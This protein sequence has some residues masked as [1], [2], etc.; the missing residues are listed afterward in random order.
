MPTASAGLQLG[1]YQLVSR[2]G[3]GGMGEVWKGRDTRIN[4]TVAIKISQQQFSE[5]FEREARS[6]AAL[7]HPNICALYDVGPDYLVMEYVDGSPL[8]HVQGTRKLLDTAV[9]IADGLA[10]AHAAGIVHRDLKPDNVLLT[11]DGRVKILDFGLAKHEPTAPQ[12]DSDLTRTAGATE[13][14]VVMGTVSYMS[15]EQVRGLPLDVR[16]DQFS[17]GTMLYELA[18]GKRP[19]QRESSVQTM[20]AI[21]EADPEP[22]PASVPAPIRWIVE[23]CLAKEP[24]GRYESTRD[25]YQDLRSVR[26]HLSEAV[27][28]APAP[29]LKSRRLFFATVGTVGLI[30]VG[31]LCFWLGTRT[32]SGPQALVS[33]PFTSSGGIVQ[34]PNFSPD[35]SQ[36]VFAWNGPRQTNFNLYVKLIGSNDTL[37]L[38]NDASDEG[39][40]AWSPDGKHIAFVRNLGNGKCAV[41]ITS[42]IGGAERK[43]TEIHATDVSP[44]GHSLLAWTP[45]SRYLAVPDGPRSDV[46]HQIYLISTD[47]A[48][49]RQLTRLPEQ[50]L[51][52]GI[53]GDLDPA[54]SAD[55]MRLAFVRVKA[56]YSSHALWMPLGPG[57]APSGAAKD[58]RSGALLHFSPLWVGNGQLLLSAGVPGALRLCRAAKPD[59][60]ATPLTNVLT[61]GA[62]ALNA[63]F[64][65]LVFSSERLIQNLV[66]IS[67]TGTG[68]SSRVPERLTATTGNDFLPHY[69][70]DGKSV[71]FDSRRGVETGIWT[72]R[73]GATTGTELTSSNDATIA[74]GD[75][76]PDGMSLLFCATTRPG[77]WQLFRLAADSG[78]VTQLV[79]DASHKFLPTSS[80]DGKWIYFTSS[81]SGQDELYRMPSSGGPATLVVPL[82]VLNARESP[83]GQWLYFADWPNGGVSR[84]PLRGGEIARVLDKIADPLAY[85]ITSRGL[86]YFAGERSRP[87]L[88]F[89]DLESHRSMVVFRPVIPADPVL[90]ISPDGRYICYPQI[91]HHSQELMLVENFH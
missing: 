43:L 21:I 89:L 30:I 42:P 59:Q 63:K 31:A 6:I 84:M 80:R 64:S 70:P 2:L 28:A 85:A 47:S 52:A 86:Y 39:S 3:T 11:R 91:E 5:R 17:F 66:Q 34:N 27:Q 4:R 77:W 69:S 71:A 82:S 60:D 23:R 15:P 87:E 61:N 13:P 33:V 26:D 55:G 44:E 67:P 20:T 37:R 14:G 29:K 19:F 68:E 53:A 72:M 58:V 74:L 36:V 78:R 79:S 83:D 81:R 51:R 32:N 10:A 24:S 12:S 56:L 48:E 8:S 18:S 54:F 25:L 73:M 57:Y 40:P 46:G 16:S 65:R 75:W 88:R 50:E 62:L 9:Q 41:M 45:D 7:N 76:A 90:T 49:R 38:T 1:P 35:G 22:L